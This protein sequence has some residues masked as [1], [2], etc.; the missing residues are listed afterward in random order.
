[1]ARNYTQSFGRQNICLLS[2]LGEWQMEL[3]EVVGWVLY[4]RELCVLWC[5][6]ICVYLQSSSAVH[7]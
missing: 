1:M 4:S 6:G 5:E 2:F 7:F 3:V